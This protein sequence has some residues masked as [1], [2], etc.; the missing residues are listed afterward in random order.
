MPDGIVVSTG[1]LNA[2]QV[3]VAAPA[4]GEVSALLVKPGQPVTAGTT[5]MRLKGAT[6][7]AVPTPRA[8]RVD[9]IS[10]R[11]GDR[12]EAGQVVAAVTD[13]ADL[14]MIAPF[15]AAV[16]SVVPIGA[17]ARLEFRAFRDKPIPAR[18]VS[19]TQPDGGTD[20][21]GQGSAR[22]L[23]VTVEVTD[24]RSLA[25]QAGQRGRVYLRTREGV[26]WPSRIR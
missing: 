24:T 3:P 15:P 22:T 19:I 25:L 1:V 16:G 17:E 2:T 7:V 10:V 18:V 14:A 12:V 13:I 6:D 9:K 23:T 8:G 20:Q 11:Q 5:L 21:P 4:A 26:P